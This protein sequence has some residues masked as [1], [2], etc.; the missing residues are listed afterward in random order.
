[1]TLFTSDVSM[2]QDRVLGL[3]GKNGCGSSV[4]VDF[5]T[6]I[7]SVFK[8][9]ARDLLKP[10]QFFLDD[11]FMLRSATNCFNRLFSTWSCFIC[12]A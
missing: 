1:M 9:D 6:E 10:F 5:N 3:A 2:S 12:R 8:P 4:R 11:G 7:F